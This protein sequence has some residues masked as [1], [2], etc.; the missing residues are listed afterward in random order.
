MKILIVDDSKAMRLI[1]RRALRQAGLAD[2][3]IHEANNGAEALAQIRAASPDLVLSD[4]N[5][6]EMSG[7]DLLATLAK[8]GR[9]V[10]FVFVTSEG[11][12]DMRDRAR[13]SGAL[14]LIAKP[15]DADTF[16]QVLGPVLKKQA[17]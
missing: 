4:W 11:T 15:F 3:G 12:A 6:P 5:M 16:K 17:G 14:G 1:V 7:I 9:K 8:E 13:A 10:P 2:D